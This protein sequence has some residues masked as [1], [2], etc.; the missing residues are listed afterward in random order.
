M[1]SDLSF[2]QSPGGPGSWDDPWKRWEAAAVAPEDRPLSKAA[3]T[4]LVFGIISGVVFAYIFGFIGLRAT[5]KHGTRR[6]RGFAVAGLVLA[7]VWLVALVSFVAYRQSQQADRNLDGSVKTAGTSD[8]LSLQKGDCLQDPTIG[9]VVRQVPVLPCT[10]AHTAQIYDVE[11]IADGSYDETR[12]K[13]DTEKLC[14]A[15]VRDSID[16]TGPGA[17]SW[18]IAY[19]HPDADS[20]DGGMRTG[21]CLVTSPTPLTTSVLKGS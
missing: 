13:A 3:V 6:G 11:S 9:K 12:V 15:A 16:L 5:G 8:I 14:T 19:F 1:S 2:Q 17:A 21:V 4:S 10:Q 18:G 20:W 7:T